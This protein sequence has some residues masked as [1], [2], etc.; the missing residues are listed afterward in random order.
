MWATLYAYYRVRSVAISLQ[1]STAATDST[2]SS[3]QLVGSVVSD[4]S[5]G[6]STVSGMMEA[7]MTNGL[8]HNNWKVINRYSNTGVD[9][10]KRYVKF[11]MDQLRQE[12]YPM[13]SNM[14]SLE[15]YAQI[16]SNP[17]AWR[18]FFNIWTGAN[19][20]D[21]DTVDV[22]FSLKIDYTVELTEPVF[23]SQS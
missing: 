22:H 6:D 23:Q 10:Y 2:A 20:G 14:D 3:Q 16:G 15:A 1:M 21:A 11:D 9:T 18:M 13:A 7:N 19:A 4:Y 5:A 12:I 17:S 8:L